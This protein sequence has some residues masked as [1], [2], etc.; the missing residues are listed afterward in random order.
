MKLEKRIRAIAQKKVIVKVTKRSRS[1][2][3]FRL[4][5]NENEELACV[6]PN[7]KTALS[8]MLAQI[9]CTD[10]QLWVLQVNPSEK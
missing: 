10:V 3:G 5:V 7:R 1:K 4:I 2:T 8:A 9:R 6:Y